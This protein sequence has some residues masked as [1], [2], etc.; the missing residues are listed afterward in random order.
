MVF[1]LIMFVQF[2]KRRH[3]REYFQHIQNRLFSSLQNVASPL[4]TTSTASLLAA[5]TDFTDNL[6]E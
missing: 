6:I 3:T 4:A 5:T 2:T 1:T